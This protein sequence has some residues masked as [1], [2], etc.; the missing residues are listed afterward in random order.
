MD[1]PKLVVQKRTITGRKVKSLRKKGILPANIYGKKIKSQTVQVDLKNF[2]GLF[3][4]VGETGLVDLELHKKK[5][6]VLLHNIFFHPV[7]DEPLH[8]DFYQVDLK[9]KVTTN[10]PLEIIGEPPAVKDKLGVLLTNL[11]EVEVESLPADL[12]DKI[13]VDVSQLKA[14]NESIK[15][16]NIKVSD[17]VK[18]LTDLN[19]EIVKIAPL[20]SKEAEEMVQEQ[21]AQ[22]AAAEEAK[23]AEEAEEVDVAKA[24]EV[25]GEKAKAEGEKP[26]VEEDIKKPE[27]EKKP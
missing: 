14:V 25:E 1:N 4:K 11:S 5:L 6:P 10:V 8:A 18:V 17:K 19:L 20:V 3:E 27:G 13:E 7:T 22:K 16:E 23:E 2:I 26:K 24:P 21:E 9:E 12:P 15:V